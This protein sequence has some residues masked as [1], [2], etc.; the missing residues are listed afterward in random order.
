MKLRNTRRD[1]TDSEDILATN[2]QETSHF[3]YSGSP[4]PYG[5]IPLDDLHGHNGT[6]EL[7]TRNREWQDCH[8][9]HH[10]ELKRKRDAHIE[11]IKRHGL[12]S[13]EEETSPALGSTAVKPTSN[14]STR[15][16]FLQEACA[17]MIPRSAQERVEPTLHR[18]DRPRLQVVREKLPFLTLSSSK[19]RRV[20]REY[21]SACP[22]FQETSGDPASQSA[23]NSVL[24]PHQTRHEDSAV[25]PSAKKVL[26]NIPH[27]TVEPKTSHVAAKRTTPTSSIQEPIDSTISQAGTQPTSGRFSW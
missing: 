22:S 24:P 14:L 9:V 15:P 16:P 7:E 27:S 19:K 21:T 8:R 23:P 26:R 25:H 12:V 5:I 6:A 4:P 10:R 18:T 2:Y 1:H 13:S 20:A 11:R 17:H 3:D